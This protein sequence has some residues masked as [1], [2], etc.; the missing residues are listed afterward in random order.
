MLPEDDRMIETC[1]GVLSK[2]I[3]VHLS[4]CYLNNVQNARC[5]DRDSV[6]VIRANQLVLYKKR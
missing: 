3:N 1:R 6:C 2:I 4:V 5:N